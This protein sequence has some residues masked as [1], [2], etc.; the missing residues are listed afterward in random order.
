M[1]D[2]FALAALGLGLALIATLLCLWLGTAAGMSEI[3]VDTVAQPIRG[4]LIG[5]AVLWS[6]QCDSRSLAEAV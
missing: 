2:L 1:T 4:A 6:L 5:S 3:V